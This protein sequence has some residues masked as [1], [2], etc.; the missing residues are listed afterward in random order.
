MA[1]VEKT[2]R[3]IRFKHEAGALAL[4]VTSEI[5]REVVVEEIP[6]GSL[7]PKDA[8]SFLESA[9]AQ[10]DGLGDAA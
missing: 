10:S 8:R 7:N 4:V 9:L 1:A 6:L 2:I 5:D 3:Q